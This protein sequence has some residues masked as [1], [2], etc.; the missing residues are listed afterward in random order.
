[1]YRKTSQIS[2]KCAIIVVDRAPFL[3]TEDER[4]VFHN[5]E[6]ED[7]TEGSEK[8]TGQSAAVW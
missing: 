4:E 2:S 8:E 7:Y 3:R 1:M 5:G 6:A